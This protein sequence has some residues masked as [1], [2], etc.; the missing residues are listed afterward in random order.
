MSDKRPRADH[1]QRLAAYVRSQL[2]PGQSMR[3][4]CIAHGLDN[5]RISV[6][7]KGGTDPT[8]E[9]MRAYGEGL[10][11]TLGQVLVI[12]GYATEDELGPGSRPPAAQAPVVDAAFA[13]QHDPNLSEFARSTLMELLDR[14]LRY[15][16][17]EISA[18]E[19]GK[20]A[21]RAP[22]KRK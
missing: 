7:E 22:R 4:Y 12:A 10:G 21:K 17:G 6:W 19:S 14:I 16:N 11:L 5:Q 20:P 8:L 9:N 2:A 13:I 3:S 15:E 18:A 1:G